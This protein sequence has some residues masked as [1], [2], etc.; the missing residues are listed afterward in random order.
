MRVYPAWPGSLDCPGEVGDG[1]DD[2]QQGVRDHHLAGR[3]HRGPLRP[4]R[5]PRLLRPRLR[6]QAPPRLG[7]SWSVVRNLFLL[8]FNISVHNTAGGGL[9]I[10][11]CD[12][13]AVLRLPG[14]A[15]P[16]P[17]GHAHPELHLVL[18]AGPRQDSGR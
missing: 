3:G 7:R 18:R 17:G 9:H 2:A 10:R 13:S 11:E 6:E 4:H 16:R 5:S 15:G 1:A 8:F 12:R 14:P